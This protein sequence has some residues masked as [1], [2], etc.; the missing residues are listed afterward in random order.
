MSVDIGELQQRYVQAY[1]AEGY[2]GA[3][4]FAEQILAKVGRWWLNANPEAHLL[5]A[6]MR[7]TLAR[8]ALDRGDQAGAAAEAEQ[9]LR[10]ADKAAA[11]GDARAAF[12]QVMLL[13]T[14]AEIRTIADDPS[15][16]IDDLTR[17]EELE[18][19]SG[20]PQWGEAQV[21]LRLALQYAMQ[22]AGLFDESERQAKAALD[23]ASQHEP[24]LVPAALERMAM[25]RRLTG[26]SDEAE[27][28]LRAAEAIARTQDIGGPQRAELARSLASRALETGDLDAAT[29]HLDEA[30]REFLAIGDVRRAAYAAVGRADVLRQRGE[31]DRAIEASRRAVE[32]A[33]RLGETTAQIEAYSVLGMALDESGRSAEAIDAHDE[34][35]GIADD[36]DDVLELIRIDMRRAVAAFNAG[37]RAAQSGAA[38]G[39]AGHGGSAERDD[40]LGLAVDIAVPAA[41]AADAV[42]FDMEPGPIRESWTAQISGPVLDA[43]L[44]TLTARGDGDEIAALLEYVAASASVDPEPH[45][46]GAAQER[47]ETL[48]DH[49]D[50]PPF[51]QTDPEGGTAID[52]ALELAESRYGFAPR[53]SE[54]VTAW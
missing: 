28:H 34:A 51:V 47:P 15:G 33:E 52:W 45:D 10:S 9:G 42:R 38:F 12:E 41:L 22:E 19:S 50:A 40:Y 5:R 2:V 7:Y 3:A 30:E 37:M 39:A 17:A 20:H 25:I 27:H 11:M 8:A 43:A 1:E 46:A 26:A 14:R 13:I 6:Q 35:Q 48:L 18:D 32:E 24:W 44:R 54:E 36:A 4:P 49:L 23:L 31:Y 21:H 29:R 53:S 16:A